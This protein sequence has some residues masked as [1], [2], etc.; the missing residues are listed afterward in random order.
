MQNQLKVLAPP[1]TCYPK[2]NI[3]NIPKGTALRLRHTCDDN[4]TFDKRSIKYQNYLIA[5]EHKQ[6]LVKLV[7]SL[8]FLKS[9]R[10][11]EQKP[12]KNKIEKER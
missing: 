3:C 1:N 10:K 6:S 7:K 8:F 9:E 2:N 4:K 11:I 12:G 5:R